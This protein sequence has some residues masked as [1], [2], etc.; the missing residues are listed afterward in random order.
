M[1]N[2]SDVEI[3]N[4]FFS[5]QRKSLKGDE[6]LPFYDR[7]Q[8]ASGTLTPPTVTF[9]FPTNNDLSTMSPLSYDS[10]DDT[11]RAPQVECPTDRNSYFKTMD[12]LRPTRLF[13]SKSLSSSNLDFETSLFEF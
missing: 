1:D 6:L 10:I 5:L 8:S 11:K 2:R 3:K 4:R 7:F 12:S 9:E 13:I